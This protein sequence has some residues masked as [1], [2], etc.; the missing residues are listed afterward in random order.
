MDAIG[1]ISEVRAHLPEVVNSLR[2]TVLSHTE[3]LTSLI[4]IRQFEPSLYTHSINVCIFALMLGT[5]QG[6][7]RKDLTA[8]GMGALLHDV[9]QVYLP[10]NLLRKPGVYTS[11]EQRL[12]EA[13]PRLG[14]TMLSQTPGIHADVCRIVVEHHE[15]ADGSGYPQHL[16]GDA[17]GLL[18]QTV[19]IADIYET[20]LGSWKG[21]PPLLPAQAIKEL[22]KHGR[23]QQL[24]GILVEKMIRCLGIY[25][26]G[27]LVELSTGER[28]IVV[29]ANPGDALR[30]VVHILWDTTQQPYATPLKIDLA[31]PPPG[32][33]S[34]TIRQ[35]L[36]PVTEGYDIAA[37]FQEGT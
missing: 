11:Q 1:P 10:L 7:S 19:A 18:S 35:I 28:G 20:M 3:T 24:D 15:R 4:H 13:H 30:P 14:A 6:L 9:G 29:A 12:M 5:V 31:C 26:I 17:F 36:D 34:R 33:P 21:R 22:F 32:G 8:L 23:D 16:R 25:P 2:E 37:Y 27:T